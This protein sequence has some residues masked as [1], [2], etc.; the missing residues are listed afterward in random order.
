MPQGKGTYGSK[1]GRPKKNLKKEGLD[2]QERW[3]NPQTMV[4]GK[5]SLGRE[6]TTPDSKEHSFRG[7]MEGDV[8]L[9]RSLTR[10]QKRELLRTGAKGPGKRSALYDDAKRPKTKEGK[11]EA[12]RKQSQKSRLASTHKQWTKESKSKLNR[13]NT[14]GKSFPSRKV[15]SRKYWN[16]NYEEGK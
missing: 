3:S 16:N 6:W 14:S 13:A 1:K 15:Q 10:D 8:I 2:R 11:L 12:K 5:E 7:D 9:R 4:T